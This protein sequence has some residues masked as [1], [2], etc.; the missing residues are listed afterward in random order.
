MD[1]EVGILSI[2]ITAL[3]VASLLL[4][5]HHRYHHRRGGPEPLEGWDQWFQ[6]SDVG[7]LHSCSHEMW[8][9]GMLS[10]AGILILYCILIV[11]AAL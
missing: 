8:I 11:Q 6:A 9:M 3:I 5:V 7:N 2:I 1:N 4:L 10:C